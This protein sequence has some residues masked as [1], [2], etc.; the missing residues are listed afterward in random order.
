MI[1]QMQPQS[2]V[3]EVYNNYCFTC[4]RPFRAEL[5]PG[6]HDQHKLLFRDRETQGSNPSAPPALGVSVGDGVKAGDRL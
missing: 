5:E 1:D 6:E 2:R 4:E 3:I